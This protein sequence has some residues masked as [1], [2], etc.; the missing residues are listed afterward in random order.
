MKKLLFFLFFISL[1]FSNE[2]HAAKRVCVA[3]HK[4]YNNVRAPILLSKR[5]ML[6]D[7]F[8]CREGVILKDKHKFD[9]YSFYEDSP[10]FHKL[11]K[12]IKSK[13]LK[14]DGT[15]HDKWLLHEFKNV[16][17]DD[18]NYFKF[19]DSKD[20]A[21]AKE[22]K[23]KALELEKKL[24]LEK[25]AK[26]KQKKI[27]EER[28]K[29][30]AELFRKKFAGD[31]EPRYGGLVG[32]KKGTP[33]FEECINEK[34]AEAQ[35]AELAKLKEEKQKKLAAK[36]EQEKRL[37]MSKYKAVLSCEMFGSHVSIAPCFDGTD[38]KL[39]N[40]GQTRIYK[41][42]NIS[43]LGREYGDGL[44]INLSTS[45]SLTA[46]NSHDTFNLG[47]KIYDANN[48]EVYQ[49]MVGKYGVIR[50]RN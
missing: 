19:K 37:A 46:Q 14:E 34:I 20:L 7:A 41:I 47:I 25:I 28:E 12:K 11:Y 5:I 42:Y 3:I 26:L 8:G 22:R 2:S 50:V 6:F 49:D 23:R 15:G 27:N 38:L 39:T 24:E 16:L 10:I 29:I 40:N 32:Y 33:E 21:E 31:C 4:D 17:G 45:F 13:G 1:F 48:K 30:K 44:H 43:Q 18:Q 36:Q 9:I 35:K